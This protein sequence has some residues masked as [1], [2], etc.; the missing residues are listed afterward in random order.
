MKC[1]GVMNEIVTPLGV[2]EPQPLPRVPCAGRTRL[3][4]HDRAPTKSADIT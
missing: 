3:H 4:D 1:A 2:D